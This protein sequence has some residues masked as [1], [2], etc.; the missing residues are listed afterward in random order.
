MQD[1]LRD[2]GYTIKN[3]LN[4]LQRHF[5]FLQITNQKTHVTTNDGSISVTTASYKHE[6][7]SNATKHRPRTRSPANFFKLLTHEVVWEVLKESEVFR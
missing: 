5:P 6:L 2:L 1:H 7:S 4:P 3:Q